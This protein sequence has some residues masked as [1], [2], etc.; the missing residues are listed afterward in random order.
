[1][2]SRSRA[3]MQLAATHVVLMM[4]VLSDGAVLAAGIC[5]FSSYRAELRDCLA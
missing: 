4:L 5:K 1:M 3:V 2:S